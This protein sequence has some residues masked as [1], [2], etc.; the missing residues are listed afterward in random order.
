MQR[1]FFAPA[2]AA[3]AFATQP[4]APIAPQGGGA[5]LEI[6]FAGPFR[7][8]RGLEIRVTTVSDEEGS[9]TVL[10][11]RGES[12]CGRD[13]RSELDPWPEWRTQGLVENHVPVGT[14]TTERSFVPPPGRWRACAYVEN[15]VRTIIGT[16]TA[17]F[18]VRDAA[19]PEVD[20][21]KSAGRAGRRVSLRYEAWD[22]SRSSRELITIYVRR[23][24][25]AQIRT[26][27]TQRPYKSTVTVRWR[28]PRWLPA[29]LRFCVVGIDPSGNRSKPSC[30]P[31]GLR[32]T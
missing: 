10:A 28:S 17:T 27:L 32:A 31:L 4:V 11:H 7:S 9:L 5:S 20:A 19:A 15:A 14:S 16:G 30:A 8:D 26:K 1:L 22:D 21:F 29:S 13:L 24:P 18:T 6:V 12:A 25:L 3:A 2:V 23:R